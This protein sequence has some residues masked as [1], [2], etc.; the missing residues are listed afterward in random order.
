MVCGYQ[1]VQ[2]TCRKLPIYEWLLSHIYIHVCIHI[3][4]SY[5]LI[6]IRDWIGRRR[7]GV[8]DNGEFC[9]TRLVSQ[10]VTLYS[11]YEDLGR[12]LLSQ[13]LINILIAHIVTNPDELLPYI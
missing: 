5:S 8:K 1:I 7:R 2:S 3:H 10:N 4:G 12:W 11:I 13:V 9:D 6:A